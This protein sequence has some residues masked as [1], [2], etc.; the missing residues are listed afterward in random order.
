MAGKLVQ[1]ATETVTSAVASVTLTGIDSDDVYMLAITELATNTDNSSYGI[2]PTVSGTGDSTAD[3][4]VAKKLLKASGTFENR[5]LTNQNWMEIFYLLFI[6]NM[7]TK[8][9]SFKYIEGTRAIWISITTVTIG[10]AI[11]TYVPWFQ[12]IFKTEAINLFDVIT[13][14]FLGMMMFIII[15][16]EKQFR[17]R[18]LKKTL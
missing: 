14:V 8:L 3:K 15:E 2:R 1:V 4:D 13:I 10:Q 11:I 18:I 7:N 6:R 5:A 9:L 17:L 16:F 12:G